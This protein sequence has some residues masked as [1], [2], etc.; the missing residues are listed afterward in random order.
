MTDEASVAPPD[1]EVPGLA[2][3]V[4]IRVDRWGV[5]HIYASSALDAYLAQGFNAARERLFQIE[6]WRRRGLGLLAEVLG[7]TY[8]EQDRANRLCHF[9]GDWEEEWAA[10]GP[11]T[12]AI[13][14]SFV[15]GINA[16][17]AWAAAHPAELP[18]EFALYDFGPS[19]WRPEDVLVSRT[20]GL[21]GN[22]EHEVSRARTLREFGQ[23]VELLRKARR[24]AEPIDISEGLD[25]SLID[26][27]ILAT[28]RLA[29]A[30]VTYPARSGTPDRDRALDG[31]NNWAISADRTGTGRPVLASDPHREITFPALRYITHIEAPGLSI[32]GASEPATPGIHIGHNGRVAFGLTI[33]GSD[34][35]DLYI[36]EL[37][38]SN[39]KRYRYGGGW[40]S[41]HLVT[42]KVPVKDADPVVLELAF[43]RHGPVIHVDESRGFG[44]ALRAAWLEPGMAPYLGSLAYLGADNASE[45]VKGLERW[46]VPGTNQIFADTNGEIGW[47]ASAMIPKRPN[48]DGSLPVPG[49]GRY[50]WEGF[51]RVP[52]L[53]SLRNPDRG[54]VASANQKNLPEQFEKDGPPI[55]HE[56]LSPV[57]YE[58]LSEWLDTGTS[59]GVEESVRMQADAVNP[60]AVRLIA[61]LSPVDAASIVEGEV[62]E[63]LRAWDGEEGVDSFEAA[64]FEVW[65]WRHFRA[66]L[67]TGHLRRHGLKEPQIAA[68]LPR[69]PCDESYCADLRADLRMLEAVDW[70][71]AALIA[72][73]TKAVD[74]SLSAA[75]AELEGLLGPDRT[76]WQWG[77]L[78]HALLVNGALDGMPGVP[79][80]WQRVGPVPQPGSGDTV[81][82]AAYDKAF[83]KTIGASFR[84]VVDVGNWDASRAMNAPGQSGDPRSPHFV[85]L[86][87]A[88][89]KGDSFPLLYTRKAIEE[90]T[91]TV[92][93]L[94]PPNADT[95]TG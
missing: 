45:F 80:E 65:K 71:D 31:S 21:T 47:Q 82:M 74:T 19:N 88:W 72:E 58:R 54:W 11:D 6:M 18:P 49:D 55:T 27:A 7:E 85:D 4:E 93:T 22:A 79:K 69:I 81:H 34:I 78:H 24:P 76:S 90:H 43:T 44:V 52:E 89:A 26:D 59:I 33:W 14:E 84:M 28:Y 70:S 66:L 60:H 68:A 36:Y 41:M 37:D 92:I 2:D 94:R 35:E 57:R 75:L 62:L 73:L 51:V 56:W 95:T 91:E 5:P 46:G 86:F 83:R 3:D 20:H 39:P 40:E 42:E 32:I 13:V 30:P 15:A 1:Y 29:F 9:R 8:V 64:V 48:W 17:V 16:Y 23:E 38:P 63:R 53:P 67:A 25:L 61:L 12:R 10:Y 87:P 50:E 77:N